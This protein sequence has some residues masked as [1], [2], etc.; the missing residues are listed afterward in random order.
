MAI[1]DPKSAND[2]LL[3]GYMRCPGCAQQIM[4]AVE[5]CPFCSVSLLN[6]ARPKGVGAYVPGVNPF[7]EVKTP[8]WYWP[9][10]FAASI[11]YMVNGCFR[12]MMAL[13][14]GSGKGKL[15]L[16][17]VSLGT[18]LLTLVVAILF[19]IKLPFLRE[20]ARWFAWGCVCFDAIS[21][22]VAPVAIAL[23]PVFGI[24]LVI[25]ALADLGASWFMIVNSDMYES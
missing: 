10:Y 1:K 16:D 8:K 9:G 24:G 5:Q 21:L 22:L 13:G 19:L 25:L 14:F 3:P 11:V 23:S 18:G 15:Q 20:H 17:P 6:A 2:G 4:A 12:I 7:R